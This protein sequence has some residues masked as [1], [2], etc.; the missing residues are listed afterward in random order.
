MNTKEEVCTPLALQDAGKT[1]QIEA[2]M[3]EGAW[4]HHMLRHRS[5]EIHEY[6]NTR[7]LQVLKGQ[8]PRDIGST[9]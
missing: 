1:T 9:N 2:R 6:Y 4:K 7:G 8:A 3:C 5:R